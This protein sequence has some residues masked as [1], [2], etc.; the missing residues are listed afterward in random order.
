MFA[1]HVMYIQPYLAKWFHIKQAAATRM[2]H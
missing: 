1:K 2:K